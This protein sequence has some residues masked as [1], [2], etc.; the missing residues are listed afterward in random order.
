MAKGKILSDPI[1]KHADD[2]SAGVHDGHVS[3]AADGAGRLSAVS[4]DPAKRHPRGSTLEDSSSHAE[5]STPSLALPRIRSTEPPS[6]GSKPPPSRR[7]AHTSS[8][9][10]PAPEITS[11]PILVNPSPFPPAMPTATYPSLLRSKLVKPSPPSPTADPEYDLPPLSAFSFAEIL[12]AIDPDVR[13]SIDKIAEICGKSKLSLAN[14]YGSHLPPQAELERMR[15][16]EQRTGL[17]REDV[18]GGLKAV[19]EL[20]ES[21]AVDESGESLGRA[22]VSATA[23]GEEGQGTKPITWTL[24]SR[25]RLGVGKAVTSTSNITYTVTRNAA[26][27]IGEDRETESR[28][29]RHLQALTRVA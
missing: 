10:S 26:Q 14:E 25:K 18:G 12:A 15:R 24:L 16:E 13:L 29:V 28:A 20:A 11:A 8:T 4:A 7:H 6:S 9:H 1:A 23:S 21:L 3:G 5:V 19:D 22:S 27:R 17:E 2:A